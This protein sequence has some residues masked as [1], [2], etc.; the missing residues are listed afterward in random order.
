MRE[1]KRSVYF[2]T[3]NRS[4]YAEAVLLARRFGVQLEHLN[5]AKQ[6]IQADKLTEIA[7]HASLQAALSKRR[8]VVSEDAGFFVDALGGFPGPYSAYVFRKIGAAGVLKLMQ[9][10]TDR[11]ASFMAAVAYCEPGER[12][13]C[14]TGVVKGT[15]SGH[16]RGTRGFG[17]DPIFIPFAGDG[18]TF[19]EM[20]TEEKNSLSHRAKAFAKF[21]RWFTS[22]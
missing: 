17:F 15:V 9:D 5:I 8:S 6:E 11:E 13:R 19:A 16:P 21:C 4:K 22:D 14:F 12:P 1:V 7:S 2:A 10:A 20:T 18:R 3:S